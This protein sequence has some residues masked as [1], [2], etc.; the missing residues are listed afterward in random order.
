MS[1]RASPPPQSATRS[2]AWPFGLLV[3]VAT[4]AWLAVLWKAGVG[5]LVAAG[6][7]R[8]DRLA[9]V[10][11]PIWKTHAVHVHGF[12]GALSIEAF[13]RGQVYTGHPP[14][15][16]VAWYVVARVSEALWGGALGYSTNLIPFVQTCALAAIFGWLAWTAEFTAG[17]WRWPRQVLF[18]LALGFLM[19]APSLWRGFYVVQPDDPYPL[20]IACLAILLPFVIERRPALFRA[21][22]VGG[23]AFALASPIY[24]PIVLATLVVLFAANGRPEGTVRL[25]AGAAMIFAIAMA[26]WFGPRA[27]ATALHY[28]TD[29]SSWAFRSGLDGDRTYLSSMLAAMWD[30]FVNYGPAM[31]GY[32]HRT[33]WEALRMPLT[34]LAV[35]LACA[36]V[37]ADGRAAAR[38]WLP[39][40]LVL[41]LAPYLFTVVFFAQALT[42]HPYLYDYLLQFPLVLLGLLTLLHVTRGDT[43]HAPTLVALGWLLAVGTMDHLIVIAQAARAVAR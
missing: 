37:S 26:G 25:V 24:T 20:A 23:A 18:V 14:A 2:S 29:N 39:A 21:A 28:T 40:S 43:V 38:R 11:F 6:G 35:G 7:I 41:M 42:I 19:T 22:L 10:I 12:L 33:G 16:L 1:F 9:D 3:I 8:Y 4:A 34:I 30:P 36:L 17:A 13:N 32:I 31:P 27:V 5:T 15:M